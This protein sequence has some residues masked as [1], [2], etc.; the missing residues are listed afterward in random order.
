MYLL[1]NK[2]NLEALFVSQK[3]SL[4]LSKRRH[5]LAAGAGSKALLTILS[6]SD[7][8]VGVVSRKA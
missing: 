8:S 1:T 2:E 4:V 7:S 3:D 5:Y 6:W